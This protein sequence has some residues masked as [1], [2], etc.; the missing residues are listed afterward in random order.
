MIVV[1]IIIVI[2]IIVFNSFSKFLA[3]MRAANNDLLRF[4][5]SI[6]SI[7]FKS[8]YEFGVCYMKLQQYSKALEIF[9]TLFED[10]QYIDDF[11]TDLK[12]R[13]RKN[14]DFCSKPLPWS[15]TSIEDKNG[16]YLHY[17]LVQK[18]GREHYK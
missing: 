11:P 2:A 7:D 15:S 16:D 18:F 10:S 4:Q 3:H 17:V 8:R 12:V 1:L 14:I 9:E 6:M 13:V 5:S